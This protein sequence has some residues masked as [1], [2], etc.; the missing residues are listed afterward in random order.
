MRIVLY[1]FGAILLLTVLRM[2]A[3]LL[4]RAATEVLSGPKSPQR[5]SSTNVPAGGE[6]KKDPVCGTYVAAASALSKKAGGET[7]YYCSEEC[8]S[9][10]KT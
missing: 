8:R 4:G 7:Y 6:L 9:K 10:H 3:G 5:R 2:V 1:L